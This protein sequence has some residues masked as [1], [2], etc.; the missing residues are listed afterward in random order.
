M[1]MNF[2][3]LKYAT[4]SGANKSPAENASNLV[5]LNLLSFLLTNIAIITSN[6]IA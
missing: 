1:P 4:M 2:N 3:E 6:G 5:F